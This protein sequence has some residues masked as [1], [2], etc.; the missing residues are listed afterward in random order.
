[1]KHYSIKN[2]L[3]VGLLTFIVLP[4]ESGKTYAINNYCKSLD[5]PVKVVR[6][7]EL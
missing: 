2:L 6:K 4:R 7:N 3:K 1:M 5:K